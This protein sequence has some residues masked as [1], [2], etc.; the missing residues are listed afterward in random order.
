MTECTASE[1]E[2]AMHLAKLSDKEKENWKLWPG[3][4]SQRDTIDGETLY[5]LKSG[6]EEIW[7]NQHPA[8]CSKAKF[9]ISGGF[10]SGF[11]SEMHVIGAGLAL[12]MSMNRVYIML[13][14]R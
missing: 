6:I 9:L 1:A 10:E 14:D 11:G 8:D 5:G 3:V 12:A 13:A 4:V 7:T 2:R